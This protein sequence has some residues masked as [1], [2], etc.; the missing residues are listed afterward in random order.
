MTRFLGRENELKE[1]MQ[2]LQKTSASL[3]VFRGR[4]RI[5][6]SRLAEEFAKQFPKYYIFSGLPPSKHPTADAQRAEFRRQMSV[7]GITSY[8][9]NDWA[10]LF[11]LVAKACE[12]S[13]ALVVLD[14]ITWMGSKDPDFLGKLKIAW[15]L[16]FKMNP[17]LI[18][19]LSGSNSAW[20]EE[21]I[22]SSTGFMG[23]ISHQLLLEELPLKICN[24]FWGENRLNISAYEK[25]KV[26]GVVGGIPRY[27]E[28]IL[29]HQTAEEN[30]ERLCFTRTGILFNEFDH[31]FADLFGSRFQG[32]RALVECLINGPRSLDEI[33]DELGRV[34]GGDLIASLDELEESGFLTRDFI[35]HLKDGRASTLSR[36][37]LRDNY[38]RF[39]LKYIVQKKEMIER[40]VIKGLPASWLSIMG[41]QFENLVLNH[42]GDI[43]QF[44]NIPPQEVVAAGQ[45]LQT[46]TKQRK[47]C[48]IDLMIQTRYNQLYVCEIKFAKGE[49]GV[50]V[51]QEVKDKLKRLERPKGF[52]CRPVLFHVNGVTDG[53]LETEYFSRIIDFGTLL[54]D[55]YF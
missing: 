11:L 1:L 21:N 10:N 23:R 35:W 47:K 55:E 2:L 28:E 30:I 51:I 17:K 45:Y 13:S 44:L 4:R 41:L 54:S 39:Y 20:I 53:V 12:Q 50:E 6:K 7:L 29:P 49:V 36:F 40:G 38:L 27:L 42:L 48:Q 19:I 31:I 26:L 46:E 52:S 33:A 15:D 14:E 24:Q 8:D 3:V 18:L 16:H 5:G 22:L 43:I 32:Y 9:A 37:R 25:F 34:K